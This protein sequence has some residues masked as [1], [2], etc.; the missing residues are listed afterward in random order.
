MEP[1]ELTQAALAEAMGVPRKHVNELCNDRRTMTAPTALILSR[2]HARF[3]AKFKVLSWSQV[4]LTDD[5]R[6][7]GLRRTVSTEDAKTVLRDSAHFTAYARHELVSMQP[8]P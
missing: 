4:V 7:D 8:W 2:G 3:S 1:M 5:E 6:A